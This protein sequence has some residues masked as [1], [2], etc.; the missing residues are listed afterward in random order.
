M[1]KREKIKGNIRKTILRFKE[2][3]RQDVRVSSIAQYKIHNFTSPE[4][5]KIKYYYKIFTNFHNCFKKDKILSYFLQIFY[6][7]VKQK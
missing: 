4:N 1:G 6:S 3:K 2:D 5:K 7:I